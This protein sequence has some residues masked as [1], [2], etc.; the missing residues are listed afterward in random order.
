MGLFTVRW[1]EGQWF[2]GSEEA[3]QRIEDGPWLDTWLAVNGA[4]GRHVLTFDGNDGLEQRFLTE[5][6]LPAA[7]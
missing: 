6:A 7:S 1:I 3:S 5:F 4:P 2:V